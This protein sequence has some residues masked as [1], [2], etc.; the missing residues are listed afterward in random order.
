M[1]SP[2]K[3]TKGHSLRFLVCKKSVKTWTTGLVGI[4]E[5]WKK[6]IW[7][8][9][10]EGL[11]LSARRQLGHNKSSWRLQMPKGSVQKRPAYG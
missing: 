4:T 5:E 2:G 8:L 10:K 11:M 1:V 9:G 6:G 3:E 7:I